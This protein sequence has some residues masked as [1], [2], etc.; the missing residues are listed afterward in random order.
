M[1]TYD[2]TK[3][4]GAVSELDFRRMFCIRVE[5]AVADIIASN[6]TMTANGYITIADIIQLYDVPAEAVLLVSMASFKILTAG[7][8]SATAN[9]GIAGG[10]ELFSA[11]ALDATAGTISCVADDATWGTDNYGAYEFESTDTID[12]TVAGANL[13]A[14]KFLFMCPGYMME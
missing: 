1:S 6:A 11:V 4:A 5:F 9:I 3:G 2:F 7:T 12:F 14:G 13:A 10:S 8:A